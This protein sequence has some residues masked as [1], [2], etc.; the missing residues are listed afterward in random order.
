VREQVSRESYRPGDRV[1]AYVLDVQRNTRGPQIVL[2]RT[3]PGLLIKLFEM[4][5]PEIY[6]GIV[7]IETAAREPGSRAKIAVSSRDPT[8]TRSAPASA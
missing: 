2:S 3:S 4:E 5:V 7:R 1:Q 6:E 8:S